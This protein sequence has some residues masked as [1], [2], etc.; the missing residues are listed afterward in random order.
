MGRFTR[1]L[2]PLWL[3]ALPILSSAQGAGLNMQDLLQGRSGQASAQKDDPAAGLQKFTQFYR[4]LNGAYI[5]T[6]HNDALVETAISEVL[7]K[8]DPHSTYVSAK[9][10]VAINETFDGSFGGIGVEYNVLN[11][12]IF[13][14]NVIAGGPSQQVGILP[15]D[16]IV[17]VD[18]RSVVGTV[19]ADVPAILRGPKGTKVEIGIKRAGEDSVL[20][21]IV[22]RDKI[23]INSLDAAYKI[24]PSTAYIKLNKFASTTYKEVAEAFA[25]MGPVDGLILDLRNNGGGLLDQA[26]ELSNFFLPK[27]SLIVSTEGMKIPSDKTIAR[28]DGLYPKGKVVILINEGSASASEIVAGAVQDWDRGL[29]VGRP[30]F[31]KGL[32]QRQFML[33][34]GSAIRLTVARYHTPS[35]RVIQRP[36]KAGHKDDYYEDF[37]RQI[38]ANTYQVDS[39][40]KY[41]TLRSGRTVYGGGGITPDVFVTIDTTRYTDY[42]A[43][44]IRKGAITDYV[45][46]YMDLNRSALERKYPDIERF[47]K[48]YN[49]DQSMIDALVSAADKKGIKPNPE[50]L[51]ISLESIKTQL[52]ALV[53]QKLWGMNEYYMVVNSSGDDIFDKAVE[54]I[55]NWDK[56]GSGIEP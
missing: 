54:V 1:V 12:T 35:G 7:G 4:Y 44:L 8:L 45:M 29:I 25:K 27:G 5:D 49:V 42:W 41:R 14:V 6:V 24:N 39:T 36:Y 55:N 17:T 15:N 40:M 30:T 46:E 9:D 31:G 37:A 20:D 33:N 34:D 56:Y 26:V 52:K 18:G 28:A 3:L 48:G 22:V 16:R 50:Q 23:S 51:A 47:M 53:A 10:M 21:F 11:D 32:V 2:V 43:S 19:Q 38:N 13:V